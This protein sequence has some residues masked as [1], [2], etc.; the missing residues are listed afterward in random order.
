[1]D[2]GSI[3]SKAVQLT[4]KI[5]P[6]LDTDYGA[7][8]EVFLEAIC[9]THFCAIIVKISNCCG[10]TLQAILQLLHVSGYLSASLRL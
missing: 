6:L 8:T 5:E 1:M 2:P 3:C 4:Q 7:V 9:C 10:L